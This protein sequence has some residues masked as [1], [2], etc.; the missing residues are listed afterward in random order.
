MRKVGR[1]AAKY[2]RALSDFLCVGAI[3]PRCQHTKYGF[4][5]LKV[6]VTSAPSRHNT[7]K[8]APKHTRKGVGP[9]SGCGPGGALPY[10]HVGGIDACSMNV[11]HNFSPSGD[12]VG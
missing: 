10:L 5:D 4:A 2:G 1:F 12:G 9:W 11:D 6:D 3:T 8:V 7:R